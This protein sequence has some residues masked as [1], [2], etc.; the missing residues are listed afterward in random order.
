[1]NYLVDTHVVLW[2][3][4]GDQIIPPKIR[5]LMTEDPGH[6]YISVASL[7]EIAIKF[8]LGKLE[9]DSGLPLFLNSLE[10]SGFRIL[11]IQ[12]EHILTV[13]GLPFFHRDP[14][15]RIILAQAKT[16]R[17]TIITKD[18]RFSLYDA[19]ILW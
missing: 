9:I 8:S 15:D 4:N 10:E 5:K 3:F 2:F 7:W 14:F 17:F 19:K 12:T 16:E 13:A 11:P 1:M 6:V 18:D